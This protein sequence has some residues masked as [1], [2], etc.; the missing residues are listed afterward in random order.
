MKTLRK[1]CNKNNKYV[2]T[3]AIKLKILAFKII[4]FESNNLNTLEK[5]GLIFSTPSWRRMSVFFMGSKTTQH[6]NVCIHSY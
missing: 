2:H 6:K 5:A 3:L 1:R 4:I